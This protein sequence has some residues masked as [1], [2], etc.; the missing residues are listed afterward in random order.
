MII[1]IDGP[2]GS[3]KSTVAE[4]LSKELGFIHFNSGSL[5][6][7]V[8]VYLTSLNTNFNKFNEKT[9]IPDLNFKVKFVENNMWVFINN[10]NCTNHL[11]DN[12]ISIIAPKVSTNVYVREIIDDFQR[13]FAKRNNVVIDGRDIGSHVF[14]NAD[15]KFYLDCNVNVRAKRRLNE[16]LKKGS[17]ITLK[18]VIAQIKERDRIDKN[19]PYAPLVVP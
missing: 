10:F 9:K 17:N 19:K 5:Y 14:P 1:S 4:V 3:G 7:A 6:R 11:R 12:N 2:A 18:E 15:Y 16:E 13:K 8:A